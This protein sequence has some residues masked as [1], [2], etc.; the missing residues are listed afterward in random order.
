M[1]G[2][3]IIHGFWSFSQLLGIEKTFSISALEMLLTEPQMEIWKETRD[4]VILDMGLARH[5]ASNDAW[6]IQETYIRTLE[7]TA[8]P[9][10][11]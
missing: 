1:H 4:A 8:S 6:I 3:W 2:A 9:A 10:V 7:K 5:R 11:R